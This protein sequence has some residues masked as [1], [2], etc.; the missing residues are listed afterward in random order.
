M[1]ILCYVNIF[2]IQY[3]FLSIILRILYIFLYFIGDPS[4]WQ[5]S[6]CILRCVHGSL[7]WVQNLRLNLPEENNHYSS[8]VI[9]VWVTFSSCLKSKTQFTWA[10]G[11]LNIPLWLIPIGLNFTNRPLYT[12]R[13]WQGKGTSCSRSSR[14][15][16][17]PVPVVS[18][19]STVQHV[20]GDC[21]SRHEAV[22]GVIRPLAFMHAPRFR[23]RRRQQ[24]G[25]WVRSV[26]A[27]SGV[28]AVDDGVRLIGDVRH[29]ERSEDTG[30]ALDIMHG[31]GGNHFLPCD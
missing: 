15:K 19:S 6:H 26:A 7:G 18:S 4:L 1:F 5:R 25:G 3:I 2:C 12:D 17:L 20:P 31:Q 13:Q 11:H 8:S 30:D 24:S 29:W 10:F 16:W 28:R 27:G 14:V 23:H 9:R 21:L 22:P